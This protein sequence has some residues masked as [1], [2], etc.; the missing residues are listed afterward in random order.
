MGRALDLIL[1]GRTVEATEALAIGL[2]TQVV[3]GGRHLER[4]LEIAEALA[5]FPQETMLSDRR[6][7]IEGAG[8]ALEEGLALEAK[9]GLESVPVGVQGAA[10]FAAGEGRHGQGA[11]V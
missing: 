2:V 10:R 9:L 6:A 4:A 5:R 8:L 11:G 7:A 3:P 1:S